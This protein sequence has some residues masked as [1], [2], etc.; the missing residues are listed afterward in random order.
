MKKCLGYLFASPV[1]LIGLL[2]V[3]VFT[4]LGWYSWSGRREDGLFWEINEDSSPEWLLNLWSKWD[5]H[6]IGNVVVMRNS[7]DHDVETARH[8]LVHVSQSMSLGFLFPLAYLLC[9]IFIKFGCPGL[10][11]HLDNPFE[12]HARKNKK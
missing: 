8:E 12:V 4:L 6:A 7:A 2:Y 3:S 9:M 5:G 1:T 11:P 10:D